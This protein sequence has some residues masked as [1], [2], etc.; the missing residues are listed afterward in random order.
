MNRNIISVTFIFLFSLVFSFETSGKHIIGGE[1]TYVCNGDGTYTFT[2]FVY[3]DCSTDGAPYDSPAFFSIFRQNGNSYTNINTLQVD[4]ANGI[5]NIPPPEDPCVIPPANI[6]VQEAQY[7]FTVSLP[8]IDDSYHV[9]YQ[10]CCRNN[11]ISNIVNP[12][13]A[14]ATYTI[15][16]TPE[17][18]QECNDS[19]VYN[20]FPPIVICVGSPLFFDHSATDSDG[21]QLVYEFCAPIL[22]GGP[23][24]TAENPG[25]PNSCNGVQP[26]F[27]CEPPFDPVQY[28][29]P[30]YSEINPMGG[31]P[32]VSIDPN[33]GIITGV[34]Q[35]LG[36]FV[37]GVCVSEYRNGVLLSTVRRD[38]QFNVTNCETTVQARIEYDSIISAQEYVINSCGNNTITFGNNSIQEQFIDEFFWTFNINGGEQTFT[39]WEP[40]ITFPSIGSYQGILVLNPNNQDCNDTA[41]INVNVYPEIQADFAFAYDTC[42]AGPVTFT[43]L[44]FSGAGPDAITDWLWDFDLGQQGTSIE[45][46]PVYMLNSPGNIPV[47]LTVRDTNGCVDTDIQ[48]V[49][50][51]PAPPI[52]IIEPSTF[53]GCA[54]EDVFFNNLSIPI[55]S[56][57]DIVWD[58]GDGSTSG[59]V[60]P[61]HTYDEP[62]VYNI[63]LQVTSPIG[64]FIEDAWDNW[65]TV[66]PSPIA[67]F[68]FTPDE[69]SSFDPTA[70]FTDQSFEPSFWY[71]DF[72]GEGFSTIQNP[73]YT[74]SDTGSQEIT[75]Y[76]T[77]ASGCV[78]S[79]TQ[80]LDVIPKVTYFMPNAFTPNYDGTNDFFIG[81]GITEGMENFRLTIWNRWGEEVFQTNDPKD[82]WNGRKKNVGKES[83]NGVYVYIATYTDPRKNN[84]ELKGFATLIR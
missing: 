28:V 13:D 54:P 11:T 45:Q 29:L 46:S 25:D 20:D 61:T 51:L 70:E 76:V 18:Q 24:G 14:G 80:F 58:F 12:E 74:F 6:C 36:Q 53:D 37:V 30:T 69:L 64:C 48:N 19:P 52:L 1:V 35:T 38:F 4:I 73:A 27:P 82:G 43:D 55:D 60:S 23:L 66:R 62:G 84:F 67:D 32:Q 17:A 39:E 2:M 57:Y 47:S 8:T 44:S 21:D 15:E 33:T 78:D 22:G 72:D 79:L 3:R 49:P 42:V 26:M 75:L 10:R 40:T 34:P 65:I 31:N 81:N 7:T 59:D 68:T 56:T 63:S 41:F 9:V 77:H 50:W 5:Q 16:V 83:P 71:W